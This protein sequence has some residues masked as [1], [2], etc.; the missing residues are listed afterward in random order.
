MTENQLIVV[1]LA[2]ALMLLPIL[3][4]VMDKLKQWSK[5]P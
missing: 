4:I 3:P 1:M 5:K 2:I